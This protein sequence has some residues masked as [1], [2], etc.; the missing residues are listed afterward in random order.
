MRC[1]PV[2]WPGATSL[3]GC[4]L[5]EGGLVVILQPWFPSV[6]I[7]T[8]ESDWHVPE[9]LLPFLRVFSP[10]PSLPGS[11]WRKANRGWVHHSAEIG[12]WG[13]VVSVGVLLQHVWDG[14]LGSAVSMVWDLC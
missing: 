11:Q 1:D 4:Q 9:I 3:R 10:F 14:G 8:S 5:L 12:V 6:F 2:G 13:H 7:K